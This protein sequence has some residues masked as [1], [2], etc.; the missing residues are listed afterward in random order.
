M[1]GLPEI[2]D[3]GRLSQE[4]RGEGDGLKAMEPKVQ[5]V[6]FAMTSQAKPSPEETNPD[7]AAHAVLMA[8]QFRTSRPAAMSRKLTSV[9]GDV[10]HRPVRCRSTRHPDTPPFRF[11]AALGKTVRFRLGE[12]PDFSYW[13]DI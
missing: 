5:F 7:T 13:H 8:Q 6:A 3:E 11:V 1:D 4:M 12:R 10:I 9:P 2:A